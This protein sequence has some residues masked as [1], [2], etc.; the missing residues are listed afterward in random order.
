MLHT[1]GLQV[2]ALLVCIAGCLAFAVAMRCP[3]ED[4]ESWDRLTDT[5]RASGHWI[6]IDDMR[7]PEESVF[8]HIFNNQKYSSYLANDASCLYGG[9]WNVTGYDFV[10]GDIIFYDPPGVGK[11]EFF[12][13]GMQMA[14]NDVGDPPPA[15]ATDPNANLVTTLSR[16]YNVVVDP[17]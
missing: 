15:N 12:P 10:D 16:L 17:V 14:I 7:D 11:Y 2:V 13:C 1:R 4:K 6:G 9:C 3:C 5:E 8:I